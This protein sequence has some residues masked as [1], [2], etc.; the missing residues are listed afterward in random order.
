MAGYHTRW[1]GPP[2]QAE[3]PEQIAI[4]RPGLRQGRV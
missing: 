2:E 1:V 3:D 4:V